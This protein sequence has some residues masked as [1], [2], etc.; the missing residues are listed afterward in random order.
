MSGPT[1]VLIAALIR[2]A[3]GALSECEKWLS[4]QEPKSTT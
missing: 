1:R 4:A 2:L 3:K